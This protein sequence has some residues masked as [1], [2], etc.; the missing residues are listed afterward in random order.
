MVLVDKLTKSAH[1][2]TVKLTLKETNNNAYFYINKGDENV[3][4]QVDP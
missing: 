2:I 1:F 3:I 4:P